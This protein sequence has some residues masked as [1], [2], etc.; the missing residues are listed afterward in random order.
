MRS[1]LQSGQRLGVW[2]R[3][4]ARPRKAKPQAL[5]WFVGQVMRATKGKADPAAVNALLREKLGV[6]E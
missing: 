5:G 3:F 6:A 1:L 2:K 4:G